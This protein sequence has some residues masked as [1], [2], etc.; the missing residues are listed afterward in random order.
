MGEEGETPRAIKARRKEGDGSS[1]SELA[2]RLNASLIS[3]SVAALMLFSL[4][5]ADCRAAFSF[6]GGAEAGARR[7]GGCMAVS[8]YSTG[9]SLWLYHVAF[10][11]YNERHDVRG[12]KRPGKGSS[13]GGQKAVYAPDGA[14]V[15]SWSRGF[16]CGRNLDRRKRG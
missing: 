7:L 2:K 13:P 5:I 6:D 3:D 14:W 16:V 12:V 10:L 9:D 1:L 4:A 8:W 11:K 15:A